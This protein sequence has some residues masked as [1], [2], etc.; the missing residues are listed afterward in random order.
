MTLLYAY[1]LSIYSPPRL[2]IHFYSDPSFRHSQFLGYFHFYLSLR[3]NFTKP[4][5]KKFI[6][7]LCT[8]INGNV[9]ASF[10]KKGKVLRFCGSKKKFFAYIFLPWTP[11]TTP[12]CNRTHLTW[13]FASFFVRM[14][15]VNDPC[16]TQSSKIPVDPSQIWFLYV[17]PAIFPHYMLLIDHI[18][19]SA[20][21]LHTLYTKKRIYHKFYSKNNLLKNTN[22]RKHIVL[23]FSRD[24][25]CKFL[26]KLSV[27]SNLK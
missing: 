25:L 21:H 16:S 12:A 19:L 8:I 24:L 22:F 18:L 27:L 11:P 5:S 20:S 2:L 14:Y 26:S 13:P 23:S 6:S 15:Y 7:F 17:Q 4:I 9:I 10:T 3:L 1:V